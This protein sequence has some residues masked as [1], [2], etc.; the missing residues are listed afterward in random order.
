MG[1]TEHVEEI[2]PGERHSEDVH[3]DQNYH[4]Q[5]ASQTLGRD[6]YMGVSNTRELR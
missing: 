4:Q 3:N 5:H 2:P 6:G 1:E